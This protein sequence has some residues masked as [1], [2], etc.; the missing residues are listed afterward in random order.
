[1][2]RGTEPEALTVEAAIV[3][4]DEKAA[5]GPVKGKAK[6]KAKAKKKAPAKAAAKNGTEAKKPAAKKPAAKK[7]AAKKPAAPGA[8]VKKGAKAAEA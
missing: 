7:P 1:L 5:K 2:P 6:T 4:I 3:L 8:G